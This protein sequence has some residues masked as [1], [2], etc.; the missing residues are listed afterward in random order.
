MRYSI[1]SASGTYSMSQAVQVQGLSVGAVI[2]GTYEVTRL[3]GRGGMGSVW[4]ARHVRLPGKRVAIK[5]LHAD[6]ASDPEALARFRREAEIATRLGPPTIVE[7]HDFN[8][9]PGGEPYLVLELLEGEPLDERL[10][11][12]PIAPDHAIRIAG[13]VAAALAAAH[14]EQVIH[15]DLKPHNVF[16]VPRDEED[17]GELVKVL[18]FGISKIRGSQTVKTQDSTILGTPQYMAPEQ[19]T[20]AHSTVD[21]RTDVFALGAMVYEMLAGR[22]AFTGQNIP[23]VV[24]K[25]VY[26]QPTPLAQL[27]PGLPARVIAA[28]DRA[29]AKKQDDRFQDVA[30]FVEAL[31]GVSLSTLR[32]GAVMPVTLPAAP[33]PA[34][35]SSGG[36]AAG[37]AAA[38][39]LAATVDSGQRA[40]VSIAPPEGRTE[41]EA[42]VARASAAT[43]AGGA[44]AATGAMAVD[45]V[46]ATVASGAMAKEIAA[47]P[48]GSAADALG[49]RR[50]GRGWLI[51]AV[52]VVVLG[53]AT[54]GGVMLGGGG[55]R[56]GEA[57]GA[58]VA[59]GGAASAAAGEAL[60]TAASAPAA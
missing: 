32:R 43:A 15:R 6:V 11:R 23:E 53:V 21:A 34:A 14:R 40:R 22:P 25:V 46:S 57:G 26:E 44:S 59:A 55:A 49:A 8:T 45:G 4:E 42:Q 39:A 31:A 37:A 16:L 52:G 28:V 36:A 58:T 48:A 54:A 30:S 3:L 18:D 19:A 56:D 9:L 10:R 38:D 35:A 60:A 1:P 20:G 13:Q 17:G 51:A 2:A 12:G 7:V 5:V 33:A 27:V 41:R 24:F 29:L 50:R 47:P